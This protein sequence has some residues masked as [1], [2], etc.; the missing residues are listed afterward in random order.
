MGDGCRRCGCADA[1][2][3]G[4][5]VGMKSDSC[6][7]PWI[8]LTACICCSAAACAGVRGVMLQGGCDGSRG[9]RVEYG[10]TCV[11]CP[12]GCPG[13]VW[14]GRGLP[15]IVYGPWQPRSE[16]M[17]AGVDGGRSNWS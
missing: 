1:A 4:A 13:P 3:I 17:L 12:T 9:G 11:G 8:A 10:R 6:G 7:G 2:P 15:K 14:G 16:K 5:C